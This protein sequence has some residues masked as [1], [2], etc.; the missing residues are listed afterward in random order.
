MTIEIILPLVGEG[1]VEATVVNWLK[2]EGDPVERD[3][4]IMEVE[5]DKVTFEIQAETDGVLLRCDAQPGETLAVG[6]VLGVIGA[7]GENVSMPVEAETKPANPPS[8]AAEKPAKAPSPAPVQ[9]INGG[10]TIKAAGRDFDGVRVSPVVARMVEYHGLD[11]NA[12]TGTGRD[13]RITKRDVEAYLATQQAS[14]AGTVTEST[15]LGTTTDHSTTEASSQPPAATP[16][17]DMGSNDTIQPLSGM[18]RSIAEH[19]V[20]SKRTSPHATTL[21]EFDFTAVAAHRREH[22][23]AFAAEGIK[24]TYM[25]YLM[26]ATVEALRLHPL[27]NSSWTDEGILLRKDINLGIAVAVPKGLMVPVVPHADRLNLRGLAAAVND[28]SERARTNKIKPDDLRG[29]TFTITNHGASGSLAGTPVINQPQAGILGVGVIED[30]V[31]A[32]NGAIV[33]RPCAYVSFSFDHRILDGATADAFV[34]DIKR[35]IEGFSG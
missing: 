32:Q 12:I 20:L 13:G 6:T 1:V 5:T 15:R 9:Q 10:G 3:E 30:R 28:V 7:D 31:K 11:L 23:A 17:V 34:M 19:M 29:G 14:S 35:M 24:L 4:P 22:K 33:I 16:P 21:F 18:R 8:T 2:N 25:P 27:V 26:G